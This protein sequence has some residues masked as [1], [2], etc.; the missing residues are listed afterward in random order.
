MSVLGEEKKVE[1]GSFGA[2]VD[3]NDLTPEKGDSI[4]FYFHSHDMRQGDDG[5]FMIGEG[6]QL[7]LTLKTV[8]AIVESAE[9]INFILRSILEKEVNNGTFNLG[10]IYKLEKWINRGDEYKGKKVK[11]FAWTLYEINAPKD[12]C[13]QLHSKCLEVK[14]KDNTLGAETAVPQQVKTKKS[15]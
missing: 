14:G 9:P 12:V 1:S 3:L 15:L 5:E 4:G 10:K 11:Y 8:D 7:D 2:Q 13:N 6:L